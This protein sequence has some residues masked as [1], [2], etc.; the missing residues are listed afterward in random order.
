MQ[1]KFVIKLPPLVI[2]DASVIRDIPMKIYFT[3]FQ[4]VGIIKSGGKLKVD[5]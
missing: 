1:F 5:I 3:L 2:G 4:I